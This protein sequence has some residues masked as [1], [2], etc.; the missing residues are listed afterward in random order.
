MVYPIQL[1][2]EKDIPDI[3]D[4]LNITYRSEDSFNGWTSEA[5][6]IKGPIRTD[7]ATIKNLMGEAGAC[8][9]KCLNEKNEVIGCVYL[10]KNG[11]RLYLGMLSVRPV[12]Q[13][14]GIGKRFLNEAELFA[15]KNGCDSVYM[16]VISQRKELNDWYLRNGYSFTGEKKPFDIDEKYGVPVKPLDFVF[17]EKKISMH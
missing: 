13:G 9:L 5:N 16:Q 10:K 4:L 7:E 2:S 15:K 17:L 3:V 8:F 11:Q 1:A 12:L 14:L 6:L